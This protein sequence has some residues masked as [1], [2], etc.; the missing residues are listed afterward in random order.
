MKINSYEFGKIEV[1]NK[2]YTNDVI[3]FP[4]KIKSDWWRDEGHVFSIKCLKEALDYKPNILILGIGH[5]GMVKVE[6]E[7]KEYC[8]KQNIKLIIENTSKAVEI[9]NKYTN[10]KVV[11][12]LHL[13]C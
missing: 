11:A 3:I 10:K 6:D 4:D 12:A 7:I 1:N 8:N 13:T 9:F 5:D 2:K